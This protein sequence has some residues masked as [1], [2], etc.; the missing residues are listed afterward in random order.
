MSK[1]GVAESAQ[2]MSGL[3]FKLCPDCGGQVEY[4]DHGTV[5][6]PDCDEQ[7]YHVADRADGDE[8]HRLEHRERGGIQEV[9]IN[10][11]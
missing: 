9:R 8:R 1:Q 2:E 4:Y 6:C 5:F 11:K 3:L 10:G 7:F